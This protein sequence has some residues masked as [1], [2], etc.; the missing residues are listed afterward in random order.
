MSDRPVRRSRPTYSKLRDCLCV[1]NPDSQDNKLVSDV[2]R[3]ESMEQKIVM[4]T[5]YDSEIGNHDVYLTNMD[6]QEHIGN[7]DVYLTNMDEQETHNRDRRK[8]CK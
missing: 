3:I 1:E 2:V 8:L 6:E 4:S 7:H 5:V